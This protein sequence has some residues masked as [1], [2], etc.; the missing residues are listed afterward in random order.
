MEV[1]AGS[2]KI[3]SW[4]FRYVALPKVA[5]RLSE[6]LERGLK[7]FPPLTAQEA[8]SLYLSKPSKK[9]IVNLSHIFPINTIGIHVL[10][11]V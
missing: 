11:L 7:R 9:I 6:H 4:V 3:M 2:E 8:A 5:E 1:I 10:A